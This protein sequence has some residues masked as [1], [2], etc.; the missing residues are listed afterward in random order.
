MVI[1]HEEFIHLES[2]I[3][4]LNLAWRILNLIGEAKENTLIGPAFQFAI[5][6][7]ARPYTRADGILKKFHKLDEKHIPADGLL[8][9]K[10]LISNRNQIIAHSDLKPK[11]SVL[12]VKDLDWGRY[13]GISQNVITGAAELKNIDAIIDLIE[14]TLTAMY[15]ERETLS[16]QLKLTE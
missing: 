6:A 15:A 14:K 2:S 10:R 11:D 5:V 13:T 3:E 12:H 7:Y 8:L 9:H 16:E 1:E 4:D